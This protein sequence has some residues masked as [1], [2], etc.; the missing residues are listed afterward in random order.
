MIE[1]GRH[2]AHTAAAAAAMHVELS[3]NSS[4]LAD[5]AL[6]RKSSVPN[7]RPQAPRQE[8]GGALAGCLRASHHGTCIH[9]SEA[10]ADSQV[11][12]RDPAR[13]A[14]LQ[15][16]RSRTWLHWQ[17]MAVHNVRC[18]CRGGPRP[19][20]RGGQSCWSIDAMEKT[21]LVLLVVNI[22]VPAAAVV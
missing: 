12:R 1:L 22:L 4:P 17:D 10:D 5:P 6:P 2:S 8:G 15:T 14:C 7:S 19:G 18:C 20:R 21:L 16:S 13:K 3:D 11:S 9:I